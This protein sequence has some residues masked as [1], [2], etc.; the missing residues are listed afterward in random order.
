MFFTK[1]FRTKVA[2]KMGRA[3]D[4]SKAQQEK[5]VTSTAS[6]STDSSDED[7]DDDIDSGMDREETPDLYRNSSLGM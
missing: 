4:K 7:E 5:N 2:I 1:S 6:L 3:S